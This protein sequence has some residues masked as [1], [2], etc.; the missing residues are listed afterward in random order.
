MVTLQ[1]LLQFVYSQ[2]QIT[3]KA[4][5]AV[6]HNLKGAQTRRFCSMHD[7]FRLIIGYMPDGFRIMIR[8]MSRCSGIAELRGVLWHGRVGQ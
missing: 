4:K 7:A 3:S 1:R 8:I 5:G 2:I 6:C